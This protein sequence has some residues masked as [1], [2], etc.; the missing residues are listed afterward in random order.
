MNQ[1]KNKN[2]ML[3][4]ANIDAKRVNAMRRSNK[5]K[6]DQSLSGTNDQAEIVGLGGK[7]E[8]GLQRRKN[9]QEEARDLTRGRQVYVK[10]H[11]ADNTTPLNAWRLAIQKVRDENPEISY[12]E[13]LVLASQQY[14][15]NVTY[16]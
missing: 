2:T 8:K 1:I 5:L 9:A 14:K 10:D 15:K 13:A 11:K 7:M 16:K 3:E 4:Q 6:V 12:K